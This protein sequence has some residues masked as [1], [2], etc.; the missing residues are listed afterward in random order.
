LPH[1]G[2]IRSSLALFITMTLAA[3]LFLTRWW[4]R[5]L[6]LLAVV[7]LAMVKNAIRIV[8]LTLLAEYVDMGFLTGRLH[9]SGGFVFFGITLVLFGGVLLGLRTLESN[10]RYPPAP[11]AVGESS[12]GS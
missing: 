2:N 9:R 5:G 11:A 6:L 10:R 8:T 1:C 3:R 12:G 7:P 4:S